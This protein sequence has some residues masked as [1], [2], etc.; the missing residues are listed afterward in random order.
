MAV[1]KTEITK[2][3][4]VEES[5]C[6]KLKEKQICK[7]MFKVTIMNSASSWSCAASDTRSSRWARAALAQS[8]ILMLGAAAAEIATFS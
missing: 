7:I 5:F 3:T 4:Q 2:I 1:R 8:R 6:Q